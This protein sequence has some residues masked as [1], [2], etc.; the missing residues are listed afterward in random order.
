M[1]LYIVKAVRG[2]SGFLYYTGF[3]PVRQD[4]NIPKG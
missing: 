2:G 3:P 1:M 4:A